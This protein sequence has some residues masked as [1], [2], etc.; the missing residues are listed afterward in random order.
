VSN[1]R[2]SEAA[3]LDA[4]R[5]T[6]DRHGW[7]ATTA[8]RIAEEA[9]IS[10]VTLHRRGLTRERILELL[11]E[12]AALRY[13]DAM[14][15]PLTAPGSARERLGEALEV[16]CALA[17]ENMSLLLALDESAN[18]AVFHDDAEEQLT[19][20]SFT[21]PLER[22]LRDGAADGSLRELEPLEA[23]TVLFNLVGWTYIHLRSGHA[24][25]EERAR[26][27]TLEIAL[28]G[29]ITH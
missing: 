21:E 28:K 13:R 25:S 5:R 14:W 20:S 1:G 23:A 12:R 19:R 3:I 11:A 9:G 18:A 17:E 2:T 16:L 8:E 26:R 22:I 7:S 15:V 24:W 6:L 10:R 4:A 27:A 29:V